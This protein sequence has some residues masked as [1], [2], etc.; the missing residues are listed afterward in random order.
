MSH[1]HCKHAS[2][3]VALSQHTGHPGLHSMGSCYARSCKH[4]SEAATKI[5]RAG[6]VQF[7][8][9]LSARLV[10]SYEAD[11]PQTIRVSENTGPL[12]YPAL[13]LPICTTL[14]I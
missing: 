13:F 10:C 7:S 1:A 14:R 6:N 4:A 11:T 8:D 12:R 5:A 2:E 9:M 3:A